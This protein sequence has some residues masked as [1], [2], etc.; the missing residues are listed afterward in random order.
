VKAFR[1]GRVVAEFTGAHPPAE[2]E[3]F[4]DGLLPS[5][6]DELVEAGDE[7][8]LRRA[9]AL[10]PAHSGARNALARVLLQRGES[11]SALQLVGDTVGD[12]VA[13]GLAA[14]ARLAQEE[15]L[16]LAPAFAA[17]DEGDEPTGLGLLQDAFDE[18]ADPRVRDLIR[19]AMVGVFTELGPESP[20]AQSHRRRLAA[21]L[22]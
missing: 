20:L 8:S 9:L 10:E 22:N 18:E 7:A 16:D 15:H 21:A 14:R 3:R 1:D 13:E 2:V 19:R 5:E 11:E 6:A 12:F 17:L 4:F